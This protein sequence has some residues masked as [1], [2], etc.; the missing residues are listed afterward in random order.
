MYINKTGE[1]VYSSYEI[2]N[3]FTTN[4]LGNCLCR[5][6]LLS[7]GVQP[8]PLPF[9]LPAM[10]S[11]LL[12]VYALPPP[13]VQHQSHFVVTYVLLMARLALSRVLRSERSPFTK[14]ILLVVLIAVG[15]ILSLQLCLLVPLLLIG[16]W[17]AA[18]SMRKGIMP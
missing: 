10:A 15:N 3:L 11:H 17:L 1:F 7:F 16:A 4:L 8:A 6:M 18:P 14:L 5:S 9:H 13:R 2:K 12:L